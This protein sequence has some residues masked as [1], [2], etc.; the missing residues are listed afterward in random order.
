MSSTELARALERITFLSEQLA[1]YR[2]S[3]ADLRAEKVRLLLKQGGLKFKLETAKK[4]LLEI[5]EGGMQFTDGIEQMHIS[6]KA[7]EEI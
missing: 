1:V 3:D 4:A 5:S 2:K 6:R 7:L